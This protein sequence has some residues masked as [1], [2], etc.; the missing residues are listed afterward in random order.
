MILLQVKTL[1]IIGAPATGR[2]AAVHYGEHSR[3]DRVIIWGVTVGSSDI[4]LR[5]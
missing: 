5:E 1:F 3:G 2:V 4:F